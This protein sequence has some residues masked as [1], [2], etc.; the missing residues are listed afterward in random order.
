MKTKAIFL[1]ILVLNLAGRTLPVSTP[2][3]DSQSLILPHKKNKAPVQAPCF[4]SQPLLPQQFPQLPKI[5]PRGHVKAQRRNR[6]HVVQNHRA[7]VAVSFR[8]VSVHPG[9]VAHVP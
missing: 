5:H 9:D 2:A 1:T 4:T 8:R 3:A 7:Q 6:H